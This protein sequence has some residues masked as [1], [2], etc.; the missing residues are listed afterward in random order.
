MLHASE[1]SSRFLMAQLITEVGNLVLS[2]ILKKILMVMSTLTCILGVQPIQSVT[3][4]HIVK[5]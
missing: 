2:G 1:W 5:L 4:R 3:H